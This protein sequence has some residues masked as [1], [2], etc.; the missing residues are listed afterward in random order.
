LVAVIVAVA[1]WGNRAAGVTAAISASL[2]FDFFLTQPYERLTISREADL[3]T[4]VSLLVVGVIVTELAARGRHYRMAA[5]EE[6]DHLAALREITGLVASGK[7]PSVVIDRARLVLT[8]L[9]NLEDCRFES[10]PALRRRATFL[11]DG[12]VIHGGVL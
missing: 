12:E 6:A 2:W 11:A 8:D 7:P 5:S 4:A 1:V 3:E 9:L 10:G